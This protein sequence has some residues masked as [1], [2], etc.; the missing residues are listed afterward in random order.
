MQAAGGLA[1]FLDLTKSGL[2]AILHPLTYIVALVP[3][4]V[5]KNTQN[6]KPSSKIAQ[7]TR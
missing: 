6:E 3:E 1:R 7:W 5:I 4:A 2:G